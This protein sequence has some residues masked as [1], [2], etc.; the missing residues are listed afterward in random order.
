MRWTLFTAQ[1]PTPLSEAPSTLPQPGVDA[2]QPFLWLDTD[3]DEELSWLPAVEAITGLRIDELHVEDLG[4]PLHPSHH[5]RGEGYSRLILRTLSN[6]PLFDEA[7]R[8]SIKTRP[9]YFLV[10]DRLLVTHRARD[11]RTFQ[12]AEQYLAQ[13]RE[14]QTGLTGRAQPAI[15]HFLQ[16]KKLPNSPE[17]L[18]TQLI[19]N[20]VDR[21]L[22]FRVELSDRLERWQRDLLSPRKRFEDWNALLAARAELNKLESMAED[23]HD[24]LRD[25]SEDLEKRQSPSRA[26]LVNLADTQEHVKR[27]IK[28]ADRLG[29][30]TEA[31]VQLHFSATAH[32]TNEIV[33]VLTM[34]SAVFMPLTLIT[35]LFGMNFSNMPWLAEPWGFMACMGLMGL[36]TIASVVLIWHIRR[37]QHL[38]K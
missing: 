9:S 8:L 30:N 10:F 35:G 21:F 20:L 18:A 1:G 28:L 17:E 32:K 37:Q 14:H 3:L 22:A 31:A 5:D 19:S 38:K 7:H 25:W 26:V 12:S 15:E 29:A 6:R 23:H 33:T 24:A 34:L 27:I 4:N 2:E 36:S 13:V 16:F 11:S